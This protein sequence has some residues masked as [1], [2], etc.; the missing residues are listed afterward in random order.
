MGWSSDTQRSTSFVQHLNTVKLLGM[1][2]VLFKDE[3]LPTSKKNRRIDIWWRGQENGS[4]MVILAHLLTLNWEWSNVKIRLLRL[5]QDEAGREPADQAL[6][7]L[8]DAARVNAD[9]QIIVSEDEF[10]TVLQ[11][12]SQ[13]ASVVLLGFNVP[14]EKNAHSFQNNFE[15]FLTGLP[16]TL[17]VCSSGEADLL[18]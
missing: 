15:K 2:L 4:L 11:R 9:V 6:R 13:N 16:T 7:D 18:A 12:H 10:R 17:M 5:I 14:E 3:G 1:S 8:V